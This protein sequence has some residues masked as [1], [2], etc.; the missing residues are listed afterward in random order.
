MKTSKV[1][2]DVYCKI[3]G[4]NLIKLNLTV[5]LNSKILI[6]IPF[7][8]SEKEDKYDSNSGYY[9]DICYTTTSEDGTDIT[10]KDRQTDFIHKNRILCQEDC[11]FSKYDY[12]TSKV[13]CSCDVKEYSLS[14]DDMMSIDKMKIALKNFKNIKNY[15][16]FKFLVCYKKL[17]N[18]KGFNK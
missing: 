12:N 3:F 7:N 11:I 15:A 9:N 2:Y 13:I 18:K 10:L 16:N 14:I 4:T 17:F 5:C 1:E 8:M 6:Y